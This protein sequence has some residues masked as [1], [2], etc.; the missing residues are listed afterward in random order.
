MVKCATIY[1][2]NHY[3][4]G[5]EREGERETE[6]EGERLRKKVTRDKGKERH[7]KR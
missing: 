5:Q 2:K 6:N 4:D 7:K 3:W 1:Y